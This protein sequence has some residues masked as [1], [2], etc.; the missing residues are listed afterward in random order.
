MTE[1]NKQDQQNESPHL[2]IIAFIALMIVILGLLIYK[3]E[4]IKKCCK[5][6]L[7]KKQG[8]PNNQF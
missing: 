1:Q 2:M 5:F 8:N 4:H 3:R 6:I 7:R